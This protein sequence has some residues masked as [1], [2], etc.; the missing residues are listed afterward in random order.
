LDA[1]RYAGSR[2]RQF[3]RGSGCDKCYDTGYK[4]R[5]GIY[6]LLEVTREMRDLIA[7]N[8]PTDS[9]RRLA[10]TNG[11]RTLGEQAIELVEQGATSI[12]E[13]LRVAVFE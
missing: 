1:I 9:I 10:V 6:E 12:D 4:G 2:D 5:V 11:F 3:V 8:A 13:I 7:Q